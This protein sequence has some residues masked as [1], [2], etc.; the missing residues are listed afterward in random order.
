MVNTRLQ[1][2]YPPA[3]PCVMLILHSSPQF[4]E[5][6]LSPVSSPGGDTEAMWRSYSSG[7][8]VASRLIVRHRAPRGFDIS[9]AAS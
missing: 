9:P 3:P 1:S 4:T 2:C 5:T 6:P 7:L 8:Q